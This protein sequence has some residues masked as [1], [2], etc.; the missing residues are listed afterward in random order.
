MYRR[1]NCAYSISYYTPHSLTTNSY[2]RGYSVSAEV[3][4]RLTPAISQCAI[5][6]TIFSSS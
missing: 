3:H 6:R 2:M 1:C 4:G 5:G